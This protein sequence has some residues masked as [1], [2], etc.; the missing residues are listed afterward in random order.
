[1]TLDEF[2]EHTV[3]CGGNWTRMLMYGIEHV[4]PELYAALPDEDYDYGHAVFIVNHMCSDRPHLR[5]GY[6]IFNDKRVL[7]RKDDGTYYFRDIT[8]EEKNT[9]KSERDHRFNGAEE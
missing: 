3:A 2:M 6:G 9:P 5:Y 7:V 4:D 8:E 1:M